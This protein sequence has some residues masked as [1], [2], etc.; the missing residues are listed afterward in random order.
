MPR[1]ALVGSACATCGRLLND[2]NV[3]PPGK[4]ASIW[5]VYCG[6]YCHNGVSMHKNM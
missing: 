2:F 5:H 3:L 6:V 1:M 4:S